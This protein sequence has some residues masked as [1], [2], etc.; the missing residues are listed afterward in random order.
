[1]STVTS[2]AKCTCHYEAPEHCKYHGPLL[3]ASTLTPGTELTVFS[4]KCCIETAERVALSCEAQLDRLRD[5]NV[6]LRAALEHLS[7]YVA[8][9]GDDWVQKTARDYLAGSEPPRNDIAYRC[10]WA[11]GY[12]AARKDMEIHNPQRCRDPKCPHAKGVPHHHG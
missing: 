7:L 2:D 6:R 4:K 12:K 11:A 3:K 9:N 1:M 8:V 5:E 10:G